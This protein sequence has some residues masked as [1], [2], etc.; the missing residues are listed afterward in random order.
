MKTN[1]VCKGDFYFIPEHNS[2][3]TRYSNSVLLSTEV[4]TAQLHL[5]EF[6]LHLT[7]TAKISLPLRPQKTKYPGIQRTKAHFRKG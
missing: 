6:A 1:F 4:C 3:K 7:A 2:V 5:S